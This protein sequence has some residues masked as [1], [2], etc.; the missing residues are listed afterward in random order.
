MALETPVI[1]SQKRERLGTRYARRDRKLGQLPAVVYG[2]GTAPSSITVNEKAIL[3]A[4]NAGRHVVELVSEGSAKETC[5]VKQLQ[6]GFLGDNVI[7][8]DFTRVNLDEIVTV[9]VHI[10]F[11]GE[12]EAARKSGNVLTHDQA[13]LEV[14]CAV[15]DIPE[16]IRL[17]LGRIMKNDILHGRDITLPAG[18][19]LVHPDIIIARVSEVLVAEAAEATGAEA[20]TEPEVL[21]A[22][23]PEEGDAIKELPRK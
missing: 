20:L 23:K 10:E 12:P 3:A 2:H 17:D 14:S 22:K 1:P 5:L 9:K 16:F 19:T 4:L 18:V 8:I 11:Y 7:H 21:T 15:R 13:D 6:F